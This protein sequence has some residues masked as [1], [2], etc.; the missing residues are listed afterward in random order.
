MTDAINQ[1]P[2]TTMP[3]TAEATNKLIELFPEIATDGKVDFD[4]LKE[5]LGG[6]G[7]KNLKSV[8]D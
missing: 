8:M 5:I 6:G 3:L 1:V 4:K 2:S 7:E